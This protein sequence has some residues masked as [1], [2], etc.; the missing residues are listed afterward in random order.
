MNRK[1]A[2]FKPDW[3]QSLQAGG[4]GSLIARTDRAV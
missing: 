3:A 1:E 4:F 2:S